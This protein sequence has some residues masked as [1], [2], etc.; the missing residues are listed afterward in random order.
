[1]RVVGDE[2]VLLVRQVLQAQEYWRLKGLKADVVIVNEDPS[3]Y[4]DEM[5]AQLTAVMDNGPWRTWKHRSGGA[6]LLRGDLIGKVQRTLIEAVS[7]AV[8]GGGRGDLRA[9][10]DTPHPVQSRQRPAFAAAAPTEPN[11]SLIEAPIAPPP[12]TFTN[13]LGGFTDRG[14]AYTIVLEGDQETPLPW[15]NVIANDTFG[16][17]VTTSG[18]AHTW[19]ENSRENRLTS[20][21]NDPSSIPPPK[22]C[23]FA[24]TT[25]GT[26]GHR[27]RADDASRHERAVRGPSFGRRHTLLADDARPAPRARRVRGRRRSGEVLAADPDERRRGRAKPQRVCL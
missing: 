18:S 1:V 24:T 6:Y 22:R 10:L 11:P 5:H 16:T 8:L 17:I 21:A 9:Q 19:S 25:P 14:R 13:G 3:S 27:P 20:F 15:V 23:T 26:R 12:M 2:D 4:L 7:R